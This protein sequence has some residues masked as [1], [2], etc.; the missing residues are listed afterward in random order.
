MSVEV[1]RGRESFAAIGVTTLVRLAMFVLVLSGRTGSA[2]VPY[3]SQR[4]SYFRSE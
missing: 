4:S 1:T 3:N 2:K